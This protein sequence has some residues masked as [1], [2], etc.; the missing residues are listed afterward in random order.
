GRSWNTGGAANCSRTDWLRP[1]LRQVRPRGY[2][3]VVHA[4]SLVLGMRAVDQHFEAVAE[5]YI[6]A[7]REAVRLA[8]LVLRLEG[9]DRHRLADAERGFVQAVFAHR[10]GRSGKDAPRLAGFG[11]DADFDELA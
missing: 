10:L 1:L 9:A 7:G 2:A 5:R 8:R 6:A 11:G 3:L 4:R